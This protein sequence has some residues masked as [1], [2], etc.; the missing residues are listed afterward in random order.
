[1]NKIVEFSTKKEK[2]D[3]EKIRDKYKKDFKDFVQKR[4]EEEKIFFFDTRK[5]M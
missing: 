2:V 5:E 3:Y 1:M 4:A